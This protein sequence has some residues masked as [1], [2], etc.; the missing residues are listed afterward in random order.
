MGFPES[1]CFHPNMPLSDAPAKSIVRFCTIA[2]TYQCPQRVNRRDLLLGLGRE[3]ITVSRRELLSSSTFA[4]KQKLWDGL[5]AGLHKTKVDNE[6]QP[7][8]SNH[9]SL[10][11][12]QKHSCDGSSFVLWGR[13]VVGKETS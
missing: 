6:N 7:R 11:N 12:S 10:S 8:R 13:S 2:F 3:S 1:F 4:L 9:K 5:E